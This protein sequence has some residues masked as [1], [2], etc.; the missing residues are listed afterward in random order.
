MSA[1]GVASDILE[2]AG[3]RERRWLRG[4]RRALQQQG[5]RFELPIL[6][7]CAPRIACVICP[8]LLREI[9]AGEGIR[10]L[11]PD[12]GKVTRLDSIVLFLR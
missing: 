4:R 7:E 6:A 10:T 3:Q 11:D 5:E 8:R 1:I 9:G 2:L 12:L